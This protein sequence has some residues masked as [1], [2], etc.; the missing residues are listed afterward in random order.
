MVFSFG[1]VKKEEKEIRIGAVFCM[2]G[3]GKTVG[4]DT[5]RGVE[6]AVE[7]I[8]SKGGILDKKIKLI[9]EDDQT[10]P[11]MSVTATQKLIKSDKV[12]VI[13]GALPSSNTLADIP[14]AESS[15]VVLLS[16]ASSNPKISKG[17]DYIFRNWISDLVEGEAIAK[18]I[19]NVLKQKKVAILFV[20]N[21][22]GSGL[23]DVFKNIF[24]QLGGTVTIAE[25][26]EQDATDFRTQLT[27][28]KATS[29]D[30]IY[31]P[32]HPKEIALILN[33]AK[34]MKISL[35]FESAVA[36]EDPIVLE[37]SKGNAEGVIYSTPFFDLNSDSPA[38]KKFTETFRK[39][40]NR[41]PGVFAAHGYDALNIIAL[42]IQKG[43]Y[44]SDKIKEQLY[45]IKDFDGVS[46]KTSFDHN[47]DVIK[48]VSIKTVKN[49]K[50]FPLINN[51]DFSSGSGNAK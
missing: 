18:Y 45:K 30:S 43:G 51:Y 15:R 35:P 3:S 42:A 5:F 16:P 19:F 31:Y 22:Y 1:C 39:K 10:A 48:P 11:Q 33:Q 29:P 28:I 44:D 38:I 32:G 13:I 24:E 37:L 34:E 49:G 12:K 6:L 14:V 47:G 36:F 20:N 17:G 50:F 25:S 2:T 4:E 40:Y 23:K 27:K 41:D 46:G 7:Q 8:N 9:I 21:E 26:Y